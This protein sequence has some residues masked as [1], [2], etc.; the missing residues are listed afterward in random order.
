MTSWRVKGDRWIGYLC[1]IVI[2]LTDQ[3][4]N[5]PLP[6]EWLEP[7][8]GIAIAFFTLRYYMYLECPYC[9]DKS[10]RFLSRESLKNHIRHSHRRD[11]DKEIERELEKEKKKEQ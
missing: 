11:M 6:V 5:H 7:I 2:S 9:R 4:F 3:L 8:V 10:N 1:L